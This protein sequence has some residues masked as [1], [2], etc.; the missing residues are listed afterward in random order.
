MFQRSWLSRI[1]TL[2]ALASLSLGGAT[3]SLAEVQK[4]PQGRIDFQAAE[5]PPANV[6]L[7]LNQAIFG[8]LVGLGDA[9][10]AG[11]VESLLSNPGSAEGAKATEVAV[12]SLG[13]VREILELTKGLVKEVR[14]RVY[15]GKSD[16]QI[17]ALKVADKFDPQ[18]K[19]GKWDKVL[20]VRDGDESVRVALLRREGGIRGIF[21][22]VGEDEN[23]V[24][25]NAVCNIS[26]ETVKK[27]TA[28]ATRIGLEHGLREELIKEMG[29]LLK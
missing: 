10:L 27:L 2:A 11:V 6:E 24:L 13:A 25:A 4:S 9:A 5:L 23:L 16:Q 22:V 15:E 12:D 29:H 14:I 18:L 20:R 3:T 7:D 21:L 1:T 17:D 19:R 28:A 26:P 8:D